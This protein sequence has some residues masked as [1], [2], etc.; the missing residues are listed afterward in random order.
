MHN[1]SKATPPTVVFLGT[2]DGLIPVSTAEKYRDLMKRAGVRC[3][4]HL[5][6]G[7]KHGFYNYRDGRNPFYAETLT[8]TE[9]FLESLGCLPKAPK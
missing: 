9:R 3:D 1:I 4:L 6:E 2:K 7:Q 5:Y 8:E